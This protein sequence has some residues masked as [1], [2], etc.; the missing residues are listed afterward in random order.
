MIYT[1]VIMGRTAEQAL[2]E[3]LGGT[4]ITRRHVYVVGISEG[5]ALAN[6]LGGKEVS[7]MDDPTAADVL[8]FEYSEIVGLEDEHALAVAKKRV[9]Q[10]QARYPSPIA[11]SMFLTRPYR[12]Q[13]C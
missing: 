8:Q 6:A 4:N 3:A 11:R 1:V 12:R 7:V 13:I 9:A 10:L 5:S 2:G